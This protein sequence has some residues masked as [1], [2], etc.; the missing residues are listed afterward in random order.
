[1]KTKIRW[2]PDGRRMHAINADVHG[3]TGWATLCG[4]LATH[5]AGDAT[6]KCEACVAMAE[7]FGFED[8]ERKED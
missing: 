8:A 2:V 4:R 1:M 7:K 6:R 5:M 3:R